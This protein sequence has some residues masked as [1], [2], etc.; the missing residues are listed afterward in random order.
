MVASAMAPAVAGTGQDPNMKRLL[1]L[2]QNTSSRVKGLSDWTI[3][4]RDLIDLSL[5][6]HSRL[7]GDSKIMRL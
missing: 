5:F 6:R 4:F 1:E 2:W 3:R 7:S